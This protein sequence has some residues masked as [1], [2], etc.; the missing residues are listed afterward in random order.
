MDEM[1]REET[2]DYVHN[3]KSKDLFEVKD[4]ILELPEKA[5]MYKNITCDCCGEETAE[6]FIT[7]KDEK[8]LCLDCLEKI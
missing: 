3:S 1:S 6:V 7:V 2:F 5:S 4:A 8:S